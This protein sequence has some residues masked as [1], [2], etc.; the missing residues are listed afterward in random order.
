[1]NGDLTIS[2]CNV[3]YDKKTKKRYEVKYIYKAFQTIQL[4]AQSL[5]LSRCSRNR[6]IINFFWEISSVKCRGG[7]G[8][9][10]LFGDP[11]SLL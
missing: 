7:Y 11:S 5:P 9:K 10:V 6:Y 8:C 2:N 1:M 4:A 3:G